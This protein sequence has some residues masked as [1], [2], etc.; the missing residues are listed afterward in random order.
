VADFVADTIAGGLMGHGRSVRRGLEGG[1]PKRDHGK[2]Q[3]K[4]LLDVMQ[5]GREYE[6]LVGYAPVN[7][8]LRDEIRRAMSEFSAIRKRPVLLYVANSLK[9][10]KLPTGINLSDD[11]PFAE[12]VAA[13]P[14]DT[15]EIDLVIVTP[16]GMG[17]QVQKFVDKLRPRFDHVAFFLPHGAMSAGTIWAFSGDEIWMDQRAFLGPIDPQVNTRDGGLLPAQAILTLIE[18]IRIAGQEALNKSQQPP[19]TLLQILRNLD[20]K[21]IGNAMAMTDYSV[22]LAASFLASYKFRGWA[23]HSKTGQVVTQQDREQRALEVASQFCDH[24]HWK[25]HSHGITRDVAWQECRLKVETPETVPGLE[26]AMRRLW[27]LIYW[28]FESTPAAKMFL[29]QE[30]SLFRQSPEEK[31]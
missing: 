22:K 16:G 4:S 8:N 19:W 3:T 21:E 6:S 7:L 10:L 15:K 26:R 31:P 23:T 9:K 24:S 17:Q 25:T 12:M 14:P 30:Y 20:A 1:V 29:S 27:A 28:T 18:Q 11:L 2:I 13:V 5:D